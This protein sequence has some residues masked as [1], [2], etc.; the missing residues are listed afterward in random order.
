M[1]RERKR[2]VVPPYNVQGDMTYTTE[3][4]STPPLA[5]A[6]GSLD[7]FCEPMFAPDA[8]L[9]AE[10]LM[11]QEKVS[12]PGCKKPAKPWPRPVNSEAVC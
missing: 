1:S 9:L 7:S 12:G 5:L 2:R 6:G 3:A 10:V 4:L 11:G 8:V